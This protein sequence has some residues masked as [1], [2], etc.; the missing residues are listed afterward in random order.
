MIRAYLMIVVI[1]KDD[2][3]DRHGQRYYLLCRQ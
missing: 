2:Q 1:K 3:D